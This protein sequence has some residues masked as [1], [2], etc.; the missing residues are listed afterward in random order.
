V[1][2]KRRWELCK[3]R[4]ETEAYAPNSKAD[5]YKTKA[6]MDARV[7]RRR[8]ERMRDPKGFEAMRRARVAAFLAAH[9]ERRNG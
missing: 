2:R 5:W 7:A 3:P 1:A 6:D 9:P 4:G 8:A